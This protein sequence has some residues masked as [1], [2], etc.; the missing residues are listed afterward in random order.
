M[1]Q[2][3]PDMLIPA[4]QIMQFMETRDPTVLVGAFASENSVII[5]SFSPYV[6]QGTNAVSKWAN[7]FITHAKDLTD[8]RHTFGKPQEYSSD[9]KTAFLSLPITWEGMSNNKPFHEMGGLALILVNIQGQ[10]K[11]QNYG[12]AVTSYMLK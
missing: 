10:W 5:D 6:F 11:I 8:L 9:G 12:W 3:T 4:K 2:I 7:G 1:A